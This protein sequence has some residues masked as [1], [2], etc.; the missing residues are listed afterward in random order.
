MTVEDLGHEAG[1][2]RTFIGA[3]EC[4]EKNISLDNIGRLAVA[5]RARF[6]TQCTKMRWK[7]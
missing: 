5:L 3:V 4:S 6:D 1:L 7:A 2:H